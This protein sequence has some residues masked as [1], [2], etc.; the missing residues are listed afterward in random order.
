MGP[1]DSMCQERELAKSG[2]NIA[3]RFELS[4][5][6]RVIIVPKFYEGVGT[7]GKSSQLGNFSM[8]LR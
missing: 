7:I 3:N 8:L 1:L 4:V 2:S 6:V 5:V